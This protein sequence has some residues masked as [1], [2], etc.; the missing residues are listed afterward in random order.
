MLIELYQTMRWEIQKKNKIQPSGKHDDRSGSSLNTE[1]IFKILLANRGLKTRKQISD[2]LDP[3]DPGKFTEKDLG[4]DPDQIKKAVKRI[5]KAIELREGIVVYGDYDADGICATAILWETLYRLTKTV[6]PYIPERIKEG[7]GLNKDSIARLKEDNPNLKLIITVDHGITATEK[8]D[9]ARSLG[10]EVIICDHH[11]KGKIIPSCS[12][13]VHTDKV[14]SAG[15]TWFL[16]QRIKKEFKNDDKTDHLDLVVIATIADLE[17]MSGVNRS[18]IKYGLET[19]NK[20]KRCGLLA[21][22]EEAGIK[23]GEIGTYEVG[24]IIAPRLN[25]MGRMEHAL[26]S[27]RLVCTRQP[28]QARRL[29]LKIG[30]TNRERQILTEE[31]AKSAKQLVVRLSEEEFSKK[32]I[33]LSSVDFQ[34]GVIGLAAGKLADEFY[35]PVV[36]VAKGEVYSKASARSISGFNIIEAI[37][38][39]ADLLID[40]GGH[41]MAA[42]FTVE[43]A[44]LEILKTK[45]EELAEKELDEVNLTKT[46]K[47]DC[48]LAEENISLALYEK[49]QKLAPFGLGNP[50]P[51]FCSRSLKIIEARTVGSENRHLKLRLAFPGDKPVFYNAIAFGWGHFLPQLPS[52][53]IVDLAYAL[54]LNRW[55]GEEKLELKVKDIKCE[56]D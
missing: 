44:K 13:L 48:E 12:A 8:I 49:I 51:I 16:G 33:F 17:P 53:K 55:N 21:I 52:G 28:E 1:E 36:V 29:A 32:L 7:Y 27:L 5:K 15:L 47:I 20:T 40:A 31:T 10:L 23:I 6:L 34:E 41:P 30:L 43:T 50:E 24:F 46:L 14:S 25:A 22:F 54:Q 11:Q 19:L 3:V 18:L 45:L 37:R 4:V 42:G 38:T 26:E 35:R 9:Y 39:Q 56:K 2:F